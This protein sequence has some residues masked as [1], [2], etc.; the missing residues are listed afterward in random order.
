[1]LAESGASP[2]RTLLRLC[3]FGIL[4]SVLTSTSALAAT[5]SA[6]F[7]VS[8]TVVA[9]CQVSARPMLFGTYMAAIANARSGVRVACDRETPYTV[10][11]SAEVPPGAMEAVP[12]MAGFGATLPGVV[13]AFSA[14]R[15]LGV[16]RISSGSPGG[17]EGRFSRPYKVEG[18]TAGDVDVGLDDGSLVTVI[19]AY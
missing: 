12:K 5:K 11:L 18:W 6:S 3:G 4:A 15:T 7:L 17:A 8:V 14:R 16:A 13:Q 19:I 10:E 9:S 1:M 2:V